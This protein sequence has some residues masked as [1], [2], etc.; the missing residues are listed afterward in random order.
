MCTRTHA[1]RASLHDPEIVQ[2]GQGSTSFGRRRYNLLQ[3]IHKATT[4][5]KYYQSGVYDEWKC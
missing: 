3:G 5:I 4:T 1:A 2:D